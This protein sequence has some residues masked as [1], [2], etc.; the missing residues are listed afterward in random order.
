MAH[1]PQHLIDPNVGD[2]RV[3]LKIAVN[4]GLAI[5]LLIGGIL[6]ASMALIADALHKFS[7]A[8]GL[9]LALG[10]RIWARRPA[11]QN[12][13]LARDKIE[14]IAVLINCAVLIVLGL[15][16]MRSGINRL[17]APQ[18]AS[19]TLM[20][21]FALVALAET[22]VAAALTF[23]VSKDR[24]NIR[25]AVLH[26]ATGAA[27]SIA[28]LIAGLTITLFGW[29]WADPLTAMLIAGYVLWLVMGDI[30]GAVRGLI[31]GTPDTIDPQEIIDALGQ[32]PGVADV[33]N[34]RLWQLR[35]GNAAFAARLTL[36]VDGWADAIT[37]RDYASHMLNEQFGIT[38]S[39]L[40]IEPDSSC[41]RPTL[42]GHSI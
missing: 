15:W 41:P 34:M 30:S 22:G 26:N 6:G 35:D 38:Q 21:L 39:T 42:F 23:A 9:I 36:T 3:F 25:A 20:I 19:G 28:V 1:D 33:H 40:N 4:I 18:Q 17:A 5:L 31:L 10:T 7:S 8:L 37:V 16:L 27:G 12:M 24:T 29:S 14:S 11:P 32:V 2:R 13:P